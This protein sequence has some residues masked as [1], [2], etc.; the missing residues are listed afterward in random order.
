M[1]TFYDLTAAVR[2]A[3]ITAKGAWDRTK[4][5]KDQLW[6]ALIAST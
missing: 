6:R 5:I 1:R 3:L 4:P 2:W